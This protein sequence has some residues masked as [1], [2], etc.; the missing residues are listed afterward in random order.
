MKFKIYLKR[1]LV[2]PILVLSQAE[3][4]GLFPRIDVQKGM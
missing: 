2:I 3:I 1:N 4:Q